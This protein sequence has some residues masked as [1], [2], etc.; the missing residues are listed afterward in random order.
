MPP[1]YLLVVHGGAGTMTKAGS[2]PEQRAAYKSTL[3]RALQA[4]HEVLSAG[5]EA[6]DAVV[7]SVSVLEDCPLF[8]AGK[9]AVFNTDGKNELEASIT[10]SKPPAAHSDIPIGRR[11]IGATLLTHIKNPCQLVRALYL[12]PSLAPH[13]F[14]SAPVAETLGEVL[15][16]ET[17]DEDYFWTEKRWKE[18]RRGLGLPEDVPPSQK[19]KLEAEGDLAPLEE[20]PKGTVGAV[21]LDINGCIA[22]CTSTGGRT[23]KLPGRIGDT[24]IM[25]AGFWAE[26]WQ[27]GGGFWTSFVRK[28]TGKSASTYAMGLSGTGDGDYFIRQSSGA[29]ISHLVRYAG[30]SL[31]DACVKAMQSLRRDGGDGGVIALDSEGNW[32]MPMNCEGMYR[33]VIEEDGIPKVAIFADEELA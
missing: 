24:P 11:G 5:G 3:R 29:T 15:G 19:K 26:Q 33:G 6:M 20:L 25:G 22:S 8:N 32:A 18:H 21:A 31:K 28:I 14:L 23:N 10:L 16:I 4:G 13:T 27:A 1:R 12:N 7:A 2:T 30:L 9:G 17:V